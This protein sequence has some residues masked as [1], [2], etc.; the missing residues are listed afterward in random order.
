MD[1]AIFNIID[2]WHAKTLDSILPETNLQNV[3]KNL[4]HV[5]GIVEANYIPCVTPVG[6][7]TLSTGSNPKNHQIIGRSWWTTETQKRVEVSIE[8]LFDLLLYGNPSNFTFPNYIR[9]NNL[10]RSLEGWFSII[11]AA[12]D[13]VPIILGG[14]VADIQIFPWIGV[15]GWELD[16]R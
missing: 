1:I 4:F 9:D 2:Q 13:F 3:L 12:K 16:I 11:A 6:H 5:H 7:A 14:D 15:N 8:D 10:C